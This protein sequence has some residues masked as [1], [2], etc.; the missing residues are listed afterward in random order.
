MME[1]MRFLKKAQ[2]RKRKVKARALYLGSGKRKTL[3]GRLRKSQERGVSGK[4]Q[5]ALSLRR[6]AFGEVG[7]RQLCE[8][9]PRAKQDGDRGS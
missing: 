7:R 1:L 5:S 9:F 3:P 6:N 2:H 4:Q 8:T